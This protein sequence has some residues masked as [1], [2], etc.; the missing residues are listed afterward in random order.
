L[1]QL[2]SPH[3]KT[4]VAYYYIYSGY[5]YEPISIDQ[6]YGSETDLTNKVEISE[7][8]DNNNIAGRDALPPPYT[9]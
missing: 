5:P 1:P 3:R 8:S 4:T 9:R 2:V 7:E 6:R